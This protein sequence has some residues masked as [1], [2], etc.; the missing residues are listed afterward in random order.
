MVQIHPFPNG[1]G[2]FARIA[3]DEYLRAGFN[4]APIDWEGGSDLQIEGQRRDDYIIA[5]R[6]TDRGEFDL[7]LKFTGAIPV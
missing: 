5:L 2:R 6:A 1:N 7:L 3:A 4:H